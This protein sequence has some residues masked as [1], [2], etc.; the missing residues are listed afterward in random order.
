MITETKATAAL[1]GVCTGG[2]GPDLS[3][4]PLLAYRP[5]SGI[6]IASNG[7][8]AFQVAFD[9]HRDIFAAVAARHGITAAEVDQAYSFFEA[10]WTY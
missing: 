3:A 2:D 7:L 4:Y 6:V 10:S 8:R 5:G 1:V 9:A